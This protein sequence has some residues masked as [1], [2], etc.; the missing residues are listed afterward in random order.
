[1]ATK[2]KNIVGLKKQDFDQLVREKEI[3]LRSA[4]LIPLINPGK[5]EALT[6]IFLSSLTLV[7]EFRRD[8]FDI[9]GMPKGGQL[10]VY[11]EA[12]FP[13][14][15]E[16]RID[17]FI[18]LVAAGKIKSAAILEMKNGTDC[19]DKDQIDRYLKIAKTFGIPKMITVSNE[20]VSEPTQSPLGAKKTPNGVELYHLSWQFI[21]TLARIRLFE[22]DTNIEDVDQVRIMEEVLAYLENEKSGVGTRGFSQMKA[23]WKEVAEKVASQ[24]TLRKTDPALLETV[25]SWLQ[26][27]RDLALKLSCELGA[28]VTS[29]IRKFKGNIQARMENDLNSFLSNPVLSSNLIIPSAVSDISIRAN[30]TTRTIEMSVNMV[31]PLDKTVKGQFGWIRTQIEN[32]QLKQKL[33]DVNAGPPIL[34]NMYV[35][36]YVKHARQPHRFPYGE[37][38]D[39]AVRCKGMDIKTVSFVYIETLG[40]KFSAP[41]KF[42]DIIEMMLPRFYGDIV[43]HLKKWTKP[44]PKIPQKRPEND[45]PAIADPGQKI[46]V[47]TAGE[48][49]SP[50]KSS[51]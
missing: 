44:A 4:R 15:K 49:I 31:P 33:L 18:L 11:T 23:G 40:R 48:G 16:C 17:G 21:R 51:F 32:K 29:G 38:E 24:A 30:F 5:E 19:L 20:F 41:K 45:A 1:M 2:L 6:S 13:D 3:G 28:L 7:D 27:E 8:I 12:V 36:L 26:E 47:K 39:E 25:E 14:E 10:Y 35:E 46:P 43:Q 50:P 9:I 22:N 42:V 37:L 34:N